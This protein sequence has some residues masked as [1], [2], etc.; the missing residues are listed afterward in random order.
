M[1]LSRRYPESQLHYWDRTSPAGHAEAPRWRAQGHHQRLISQDSSLTR[2]RMMLL[3]VPSKP[4]PTTPPPL[5]RLPACACVYVPVHDH[6]ACG[7]K[8]ESRVQLSGG[9]NKA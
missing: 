5:A 1:P 3:H 9:S 2:N 7:S 6:A 4:D 8:A